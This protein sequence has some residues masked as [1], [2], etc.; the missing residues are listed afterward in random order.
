MDDYLAHL[1][2]FRRILQNLQGQPAHSLNRDAIAALT[3]KL[4]RDESQLNTDRLEGSIR[5]TIEATH[6]LEALEHY[7]QDVMAVFR[8][9]TTKKRHE[10]EL[11]RFHKLLDQSGDSIFLVEPYTGRFLDVNQTATR[12]LGY[13]REELLELSLN[14]IEV[15]LRLT[16]ATVWHEWVQSMRN[17]HD[18]LYLEGMHR[19]HDGTRFPVE[20]SVGFATVD[21]EELLLLVTRDIAARKRSENRLRRQWGFFSGLVHRSID[22][23]MGFD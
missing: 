22:G 3:Q 5:A 19:R 17:A 18:V 8:E 4:D 6:T 10:L 2:E 11:E 1:R 23:I 13:S 20:A 12:V 21:N 14:Y 9:T 7:E 15:G 16:P